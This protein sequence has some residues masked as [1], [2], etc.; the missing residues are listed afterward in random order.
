[1]CTYRHEKLAVLLIRS[2]FV[3]VHVVLTFYLLILN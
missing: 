2:L 1:M 3:N